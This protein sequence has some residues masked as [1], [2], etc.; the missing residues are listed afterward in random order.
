VLAAPIAMWQLGSWP[1][2]RFLALYAAPLFVAAPWWV[3]ERLRSL[4]NSSAYSTSLLMVD[5]TV[6][7]L[8]M[9]R[10]AFGV[11]LLFSGHMLFLT[12]TG[13]TTSRRPYQ[14]FALALAIE[15]TVFKL[16]VWHDPISWAVGVGLGLVAAL[17]ARVS[18]FQLTR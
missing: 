9:A 10:F 3:R 1:A 2:A 7:L 13:L 14:W 15:T 18:P 11:T 4:N 8:S 16:L 12:Y 17:I 5:A 6:L